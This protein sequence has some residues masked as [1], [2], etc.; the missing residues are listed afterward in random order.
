MTSWPTYALILSDNYQE[1]ADWGV[2]RTDMD[3]GIAKQR[4]R[5]SKA[6][7]LRTITAFVHTS[8][9]RLSFDAWL[10]T[11]LSG[12]VDWFNYTDPVDSVVKQ[13]RIVGQVQWQPNGP[14]WSA[15]IQVE[16]IG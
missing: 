11:G 10:E 6:I 14:T 9:D 5:Y 15:Q 12:G 4:A 8:T 7:V 2:L 16:S 1:A 13:A 3:G